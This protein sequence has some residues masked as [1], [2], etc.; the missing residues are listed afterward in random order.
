M[1]KLRR[2]AEVGDGSYEQMVNNNK[3]VHENAID[4]AKRRKKAFASIPQNQI[5]STHNNW[6]ELKGALRVSQKSFDP[7]DYSS[8]DTSGRSVKRYET[9]N[10]EYI[11][12]YDARASSPMSLHMYSDALLDI[13]E[14]LKESALRDAMKKESEISHEIKQLQKSQQWDQEA[15]AW[16]QARLRGR[17]DENISSSNIRGNIVKT[18]NEHTAESRF[19]QTDYDAMN[20]RDSQKQEMLAAMQ[21]RHRS[22]KD[23]RI[24][25]TKEQKKSQWENDDNIRSQSINKKTLENSKLFNKL[26]QIIEE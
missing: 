1:S 7:N 9:D 23:S 11:D 15:N 19:G 2:I 10:D 25:I 3:N 26:S 6:E 5:S 22:I 17:N 14:S 8:Y 12:S 13:K 18:A 21:Q 24:D 16:A 20:E 4:A